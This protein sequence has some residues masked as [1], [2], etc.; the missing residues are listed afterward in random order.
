M[1][2][3]ATAPVVYVVD[4]DNEVLGSLKF[5]LESDGF[6]V[7]TFRSGTALLNAMAADAN[8]F[9]IDYKMPA[10]SGIDLA[11]RL[12][13]RDIDVPIILI[14]GYPDD[15][16]MDR[17]AIAGIRHVVLKPHL[18]DSLANHIRAAIRESRSC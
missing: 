11:R 13:S 2:S 16:I 9:V 4:D 5:L 8:C 3:A 10:M 12:R 1:V 17:A 7:R 6:D 18:D 15:R 14:T